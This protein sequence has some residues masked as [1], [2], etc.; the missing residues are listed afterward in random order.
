M[1]PSVENLSSAANDA[2]SRT[3]RLAATPLKV[4][5]AFGWLKSGKRPHQF[6]L[7]IAFNSGHA[8]D[9]PPRDFER[10]VT[11]SFAAQRLH[12]KNHFIRNVIRL[13]RER[14]P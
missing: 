1:I 3:V 13:W 5:R 11:K 12:Q 8:N 9:L 14:R 4:Y 10:Y 6:S 7:A 2:F